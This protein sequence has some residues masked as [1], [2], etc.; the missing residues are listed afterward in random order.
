[1]RRAH[2]L[3]QRDTCVAGGYSYGCGLLQVAGPG[4]G[5]LTLFGPFRFHDSV[6]GVANPV[7][8][9]SCLS[10]AVGVLSL[11]FNVSPVADAARLSPIGLP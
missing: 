4:A 3:D 6:T 1:M 11:T 10:H 9:V 5:E 2:S 8:H 7:H